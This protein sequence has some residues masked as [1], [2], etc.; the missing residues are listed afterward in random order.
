MYKLYVFACYVLVIILYI[1][2]I[3]TGHKRNLT[4]LKFLW[5]SVANLFWAQITG[6]FSTSSKAENP[7][8]RPT[9]SGFKTALNTCI[10][11]FNHSK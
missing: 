9:Q 7:L 1:L 3:L 6:Q 4:M 11:Q 10:V 5:K 8:K 2:I